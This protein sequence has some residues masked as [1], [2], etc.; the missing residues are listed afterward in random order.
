MESYVKL[1]KLGEVCFLRHNIHCTYCMIEYNHV[2]VFSNLNSMAGLWIL[3]L[4]CLNKTQ[5]HT[6]SVIASLMIVIIIIIIVCKV[7]T[8]GVKQRHD[9]V[10]RYIFALETCEKVGFAKA[11]KW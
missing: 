8:K 1:D 9:N 2:F 7:S 11:E 3:L 4:F 5:K 10:V 6:C